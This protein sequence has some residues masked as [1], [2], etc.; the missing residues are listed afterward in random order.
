M[1]V[2][3]Q[4]GTWRMGVPVGAGVDADEDA[5]A[6]TAALVTHPMEL[7]PQW[8]VSKPFGQRGQP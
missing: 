5:G 3:S 7:L 8:E 1:N 4:M 6:F 2:C